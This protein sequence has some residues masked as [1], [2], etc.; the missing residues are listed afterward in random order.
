MDVLTD[1][2]MSIGKAV[3]RRRGAC[4]GAARY[5]L[6]RDK[7]V[8]L[9]PEEQLIVAQ[10]IAILESKLL[11]EAQVM[12]CPA[13]LKDWLHLH[14]GLLTREVFGLL[15]LNAQ[16][17]L[18]AHEQLFF[19]SLAETAVYPRE[20]ARCAFHHNAA[21]VIA[22]HCH[23]S[24]VPE[25]SQ[26]DQLL[27]VRLKQSLALVDI[28]LLDHFIVAGNQSLSFSERGLM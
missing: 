1:A 28:R 18:I 10:A 26:A 15:L 13:S 27:T 22:V 12:S 5:A 4:G 2:S 24:G 3:S 8:N 11:R 6:G 21:A 9:K 16:L 17:R 20:V 25:P 7:A 14:Y 23:P 19:G